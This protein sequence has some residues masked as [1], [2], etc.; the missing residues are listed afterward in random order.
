[1]LPAAQR[2]GIGRWAMV[3]KIIAGAKCS[4]Q[5][6]RNRAGSESRMWPDHLVTGPPRWM[7]NRR[8]WAG[9]STTE[10]LTR[11]DISRSDG[12]RTFHARPK[13]ASIRIDK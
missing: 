7:A 4:N 2:T 10:P 8:Y 6:T 12:R 5:C 1:M 9:A 11:L 3:C 13:S